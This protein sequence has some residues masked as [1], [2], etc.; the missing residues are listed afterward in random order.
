MSNIKF[1]AIQKITQKNSTE[2]NNA[3]NKI[4]SSGWFLRGNEVKLFEKKSQTTSG[5]NIVLELPM[6]WMP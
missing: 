6:N 2:I 4:L 5:Q 3:I 1:L